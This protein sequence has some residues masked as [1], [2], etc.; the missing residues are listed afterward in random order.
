MVVN[1]T[2]MKKQLYYDHGRECQ[3]FASLGSNSRF[4]LSATVRITSCTQATTVVL[5]NF[6]ADRYVLVAVVLW[7]KN[8]GR[9]QFA[10][11][12]SCYPAHVISSRFQPTPSAISKRNS[13]HPLILGISY[14]GSILSRAH[15]ANQCGAVPFPT[16]V[17]QSICV[18]LMT[19]LQ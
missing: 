8:N 15:S 14:H 12:G 11:Q 9:V 4:S 17:V 6:E 5:E 19:R 3:R 1:R 2:I 13:Q 7:S 16:E 10:T 18:R